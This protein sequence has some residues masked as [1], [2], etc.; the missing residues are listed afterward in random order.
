M[1]YTLPRVLARLKLLIERVEGQ[2]ARFGVGAS[3][4]W[5][6][7]N[8][9]IFLS[10]EGADAG[11]VDRKRSGEDCVASEDATH[12]RAST[13]GER[14]SALTAARRVAVV[15]EHGVNQA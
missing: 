4:S 14:V 8:H 1:A 2:N 5:V 10:A 3:A 11:L 12:R 6:D 7:A 9:C 15:R 13:G